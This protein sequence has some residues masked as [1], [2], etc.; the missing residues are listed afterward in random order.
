MSPDRRRDTYDPLVYAR[1]VRDQA[2]ERDFGRL[3]DRLKVLA[4]S[5]TGP[6]AEMLAQARVELDR[7]AERVD[8]PG[9]SRWPAPVPITELSG[10]DTKSSSCGTAASPAV[11][12]RFWPR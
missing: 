10:P 9:L 12:S 11:T 4:E 3:A 5:P 6:P 8:R 7:L 2:V 1:R